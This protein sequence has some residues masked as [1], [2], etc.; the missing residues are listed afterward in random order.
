[1]TKKIDSMLPS[2]MGK[3]AKETD[4]RT[5]DMK[6]SIDKGLSKLLEAGK[7]TTTAEKIITALR[8]KWLESPIPKAGSMVRTKD[9]LKE[10]RAKSEA[11]SIAK[12]ITAGKEIMRVELS[13][14]RNSGY[15]NGMVQ[16]L[17]SAQTQ[18][19]N[20]LQWLA[21]MLPEFFA[22]KKEKDVFGREIKQFS[23]DMKAD[24]RDNLGLQKQI[25]AE[26]RKLNQNMVGS[27]I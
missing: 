7:I 13:L 26:L 18:T 10:M 15:I 12:K 17:S 23:I 3:S 19:N 21:R 22:I 5:S 2:W 27:E 6:N 14:Q 25:L 1:M 9:I 4:Q 11:D 20:A 8:K 16:P 24:N